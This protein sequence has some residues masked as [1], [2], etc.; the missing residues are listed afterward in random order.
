LPDGV[1]V[2]PGAAKVRVT[3]N[4]QSVSYQLEEAYPADSIIAELGRRLNAEGWHPVK[5]DVANPSVSTMVGQGWGSYEDGTR[6]PAV[7]VWEWSQQWEN[8][9]QRVV[10]YVLR[11]ETVLRGEP[12]R[13]PEGPLHVMAAALSPAA[14]KHLRGGS[15]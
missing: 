4:N 10:W 7:N 5:S 14:V 13:S 3:D 1:I 12:V 8:S 2:L 15:K 11:Y 9:Q 6:R